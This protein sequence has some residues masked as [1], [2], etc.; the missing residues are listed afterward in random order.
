MNPPL[1]RMTDSNYACQASY[2]NN[3]SLSINNS[4]AKDFPAECLAQRDLPCQA[5]DDF[6]L[7]QF[8]LN[9]DLVLK[10]LDNQAAAIG[11]ER[12]CI[13]ERLRILAPR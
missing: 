5:P 10:K 12:D 7:R 13:R 6:L 9:G 3:G 2:H 1:E 11:K 4:V 8:H